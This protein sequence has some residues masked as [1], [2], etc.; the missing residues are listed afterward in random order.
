MA[1]SAELRSEQAA[2][3][4]AVA[5]CL[6]RYRGTSRLYPKADLR[7]YLRWCAGEILDPLTAARGDI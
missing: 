7:V 4:Q 5:A 3:D 6:G 2:F 1:T